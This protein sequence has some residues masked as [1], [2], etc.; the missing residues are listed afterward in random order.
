MLPYA[1]MD[2]FKAKARFDMN[3]EEELAER[4]EKAE[5][6]REEAVERGEVLEVDK[7]TGFGED[8]FGATALRA[9]AEKWAE[10][11]ATADNEWNLY[12]CMSKPASEAVVHRA[13]LKLGINVPEDENFQ[14]SDV[15][16]NGYWTI[17]EKEN[18]SSIEESGSVGYGAGAYGSPDD[19]AASA[20]LFTPEWWCET[21][22]ITL[23]GRLDL[24][25]GV[26]Q[27]TIDRNSTESEDAPT[28]RG[29]RVLNTKSKE[30]A[31]EVWQLTGQS[32]EYGFR[33]AVEAT[34]DDLPNGQDLVGGFLLLKADVSSSNAMADD[35]GLRAFQQLAPLH[36]KQGPLADI[37]LMP[38]DAPDSEERE[39]AFE[40][41]SV[42]MRA[43][44]VSSAN[45]HCL[46]V[47]T[48]A[49]LVAA[50]A[51]IPL[52]PALFY[53]DPVNEENDG[54]WR[55]L[56][57]DFAQ[58]AYQDVEG[59]RR[60]LLQSF[61][62]EMARDLQFLQS[63]TLPT[64]VKM[65]FAPLANLLNPYVVDLETL[66]LRPQHW[67]ISEEQWEKLLTIY[68]KW[69]HRLRMFE[70]IGVPITKALVFLWNYLFISTARL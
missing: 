27:L 64:S 48:T 70:L 49:S 13:V 4:S 55:I 57:T 33:G 35:F 60:A 3:F 46:E 67:T 59:L 19:A 31:N 58:H 16:A 52:F 15:T 26:L 41:L 43:Y 61:K 40:Q 54:P 34:S 29:K 39:I 2:S 24:S 8:P 22:A 7:H 66:E 65:T 42:S 45:H 30:P 14:T 5:I 51:P 37:H 47:L 25:F 38:L 36:V 1:L 21:H 28:K 12:I 6:Q 68:Y 17:D 32:F 50:Q 10:R 11:F 18:L 56:R 62:H 9:K 63:L 69:T 44:M 53:L 23:D 20:K